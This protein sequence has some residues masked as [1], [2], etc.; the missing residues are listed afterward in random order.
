MIATVAACAVGAY[1]AALLPSAG[2]VAAI[3]KISGSWA[4]VIMALSLVN[5]DTFNAY[6]GS[7]QILSLLNSFRR[8][9][10]RRGCGSS[11]SCSRWPSAWWSPSSATSRS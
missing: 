1:M 5:A 2:S 11:R 3:G 8:L 4:L 7:F 9:G 6:T 10:P